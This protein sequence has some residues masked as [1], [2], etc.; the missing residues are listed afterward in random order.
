[1]RASE[2]RRYS[3]VALNAWFASPSRP[4]AFEAIAATLPPGSVGYDPEANEQGE[5][6][7]WLEDAMAHLL[8]PRAPTVLCSARRG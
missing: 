3:N 5:R 2:S 7:I 6:L 1:M 4:D 8:F